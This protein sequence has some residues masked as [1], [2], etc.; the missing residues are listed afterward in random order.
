MNI[1][2]VTAMNVRIGVLEHSVLQAR[3]KDKS[4]LQR[5]MFA[6]PSQDGVASSFFKL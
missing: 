4:N 6:L 1:S 2:Q 5:D 3:L